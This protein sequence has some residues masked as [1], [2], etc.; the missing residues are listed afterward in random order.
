MI[1][2]AAETLLKAHDLCKYFYRD[3]GW[4][5]RRAKV[6]QAVDHGDLDVQR[7]ETLA[8]VGESGSGKTTLGKTL[9]RI[10]KPTKGTI[11]FE[12][13][14][15]SAV[16]RNELKRL[17]KQMQMVFQDPSSS[18]NP[19]R[20]I[21]DAVSLPLKIHERS[22]RAKIRRRVEELL[23]AVDLPKEFLYRYPHTLSGGQKQR[24]A[25]ARALA[26]DPKLIVLDEP[27]S[28]LD[29]SVQAKILE[30]LIAL[31]KRFQLTYIYISH[32][33]SVVR[34]ISDRTA[35]MYLGRIV[36]IAPTDK[37]F[38]NPLHPYT[39]ALL[40]AIPVLSKE[41]QAL[42][43]EE[44]TL[45]GETPSPINVSPLCVFLSRCPK[46]IPICQG[47]IPPLIQVEAGHYVRCHLYP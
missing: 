11:W 23:E 15:I 18:L 3:G 46:K 22:S 28:A 19:R 20:T 26:S 4:W 21:F 27:S 24:V 12:G 13:R 14:E 10:Y 16:D 17:R 30:L 29:V 34:N 44:I 40:S 47:E 33:L 43:P 2:A 32:D 6:I 5:G 1:A 37:L 9:V 25:I 42:I 39:R 36:E 45:E 35:V 38:Q 8:I 41:E 31:Q 7:G